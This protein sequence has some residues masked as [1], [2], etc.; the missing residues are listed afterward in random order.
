MNA[1]SINMLV[2]HAVART[3]TEPAPNHA[4]GLRAGFVTYNNLMGAIGQDDRPSDPSR[5]LAPWDRTYA[6]TMHGPTTRAG[7]STQEPP[8]CRWTPGEDRSGP[9]YRHRI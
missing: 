8:L 9:R 2:K 1:N 6:Y 5:S 7:S 3:G 4:H